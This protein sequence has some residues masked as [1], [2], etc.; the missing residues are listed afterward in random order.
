M[1][2]IMD[3]LLDPGNLELARTRCERYFTLGSHRGL[4]VAQEKNH[5]RPWLMSPNAASVFVRLKCGDPGVF[6]TQHKKKFDAPKPT[7]SDFEI[8]PV[9]TAACAAAGKVFGASLT[10]IGENRLPWC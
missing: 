9:V 2:I 6:G 5:G 4:I 10:G 7:G 3:R 8:V 1:L